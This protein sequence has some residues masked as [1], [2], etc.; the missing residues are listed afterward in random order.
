MENY[1]PVD[2]EVIDSDVCNIIGSEQYHLSMVRSLFP[3]LKERDI[4]LATCV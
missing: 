4:Y 3:K 1:C 2:C